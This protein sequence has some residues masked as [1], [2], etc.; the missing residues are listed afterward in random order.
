MS[1]EAA[2]LIKGTIE[3]LAQQRSQIWNKIEQCVESHEE[4][5]K[6]AGLICTIPG[7]G[8]KTAFMALAEL[9]DLRSWS[10]QE[11][12][13]YAG[14]YPRQHTSGTSVASP[15]RIAGG[16]GARIRRA[17]FLPCCSLSHLD[18]PVTRWR[19]GLFD[20][21]KAKMAA[22]VALIKKVLLLMRT[23]VVTG[24]A[25]NPERLSRHTT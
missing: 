14:L 18:I 4:L 8:K 19:K 3:G 16:G 7:I 25:Y 13:S 21:G 17:L 23:V 5:K 12:V 15:P 11:I 10:R 6:E 22:I 2:T 24:Q 20:R 9:G 1:E